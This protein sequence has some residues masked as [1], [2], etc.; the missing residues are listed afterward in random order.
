MTG[1]EQA[2]PYRSG[3][4]TYARL[5]PRAYSM[6]LLVKTV[7]PLQRDVLAPG[8]GNPHSPDE[9]LPVA[10]YLAALRVLTEYV[11]TISDYLVN[12]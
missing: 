2:A 5:L 6:G 12:E 7:H 10:S 1:D 11:M 4:L 8:H 3:G 9:G